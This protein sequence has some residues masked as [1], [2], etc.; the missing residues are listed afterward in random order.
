MYLIALIILGDAVYR[1]SK[2][3]IAYKKTVYLITNLRVVI[4]K[5]V[6]KDSITSL[7]KSKIVF[8]DLKASKTEQRFNVGTILIHLGEIR[9]FDGKKEKVFYKLESVKDP[10]NILR[11]L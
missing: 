10:N 6:I 7:Y 8:L 4:K 5:G 1:F 2:K 3:I 9:D 11:L